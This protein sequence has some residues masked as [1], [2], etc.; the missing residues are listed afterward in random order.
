M[1]IIADENEDG[2]RWATIEVRM[3][4]AQEEAVNAGRAFPYAEMITLDRPA[5]GSRERVART[6]DHLQA[7]CAAGPYAGFSAAGAARLA[8]VC[9]G[10]AALIRETDDDPICFNARLWARFTIAALATGAIA[11]EACPVS[12]EEEDAVVRAAEEDLDQGR[13]VTWI[14]RTRARW[15]DGPAPGET[16]PS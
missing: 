4:P 3:T 5:P 14:A 11:G 16:P 15:Q 13:K 8:V 7:Q 10:L 2:R 6:L 12:A 9:A 1:S